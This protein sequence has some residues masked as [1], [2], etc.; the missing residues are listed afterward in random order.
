MGYI[1]EESI[2]RS[3]SKRMSRYNAQQAGESGRKGSMADAEPW[4]V[5]YIQ[6]G[7]G[8]EKE[9]RNPLD[10]LAGDIFCAYPDSCE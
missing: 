3:H 9:G 7:G 8:N 4:V 10:D 5:F 6:N 2:A 1:D